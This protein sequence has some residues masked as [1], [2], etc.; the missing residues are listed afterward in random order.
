MSKP[1]PL[2]G[3]TLGGIRIR[4]LLGRG[5]MGAVY[6]GYQEKL[7]R[8]LAVKVM[9]PEHAKNPIAA[10]YFLR[11]ARSASGLRHPNIIQIYDF[12]E[13][14][15]FPYIAMEFV[16][17]QSLEDLIK[18][19][20]PLAP[21][22]ITH[23]LDQTLSALE[24]AHANH[25]IHRDLKPEN[26]MI[27]EG[28]DGRDFV[29]ILDFG[30][31][32]PM[33]DVS[34]L[35]RQGAMVGTPHY[36]SPEQARGEP[37]DRRSDLFSMGIVLYQMLTNLLPFTD[38]ALAN[39]L[40]KLIQEE[41]LS[42]SA[43][44]PDVEIHPGLESICFRAMKKK[45]QERYDSAGDFRRALASVHEDGPIA[46]AEDAP[47]M[48]VFKRNPTEVSRSKIAGLKA[49]KARNS[50]SLKKPTSHDPQLFEPTSEPSEGAATAEPS[51]ARVPGRVATLNTPYDFNLDEFKQDLLGQ[52]SLA[53]V[54]VVHQRA[55]QRIEIEEQRRLR[56][57]LDEQFE[58]IAR[59]FG[60]TTHSRRGDCMPIIFGATGA[61]V[62]DPLR[63]AEAAFR[64]REIL[65]R[66]SPEHV[67][68]G[69]AMAQG[70]VHVPPDGDVTRASG[71]PLDEAIEQA[72][73][74]EDERVVAVG[75]QLRKRLIEVYELGAPVSDASVILGVQ[76]AARILET[77]EDLIGREGEV[78]ELLA[79]LGQL[80]RKGGAAFVL[81]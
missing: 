28:R 47:K 65:R 20:Y 40:I 31:A 36:M 76:A 60:G 59:D 42:P 71:Q 80:G 13:E 68:F 49:R 33:D 7:E 63:A 69:F 55:S 67:T 70:N 54:L 44:R 46:K 38:K 81:T 35:T 5:G 66:S 73:A 64:L 30:I 48:F 27:E 43:A 34:P 75:E 18:A 57:A 51:P 58:Q 29:K 77:E 3:R 17:G 41:P 15:G 53:T 1:D 62:D 6:E 74:A 72:R 23:I 21:E 79:G 19:E 10:E 14:D 56:G 50:G 4:K 9:N 11:E 26:L 22:R 16:P 52:Q 2:L 32:K 37:V 25:I 8:K 12:G 61:H 24:E 39:I 45:P 78:A